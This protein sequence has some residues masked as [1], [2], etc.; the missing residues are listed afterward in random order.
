[1]TL[2]LSAHFYVIIY[3]LLQRV[4]C[5]SGK[6]IGDPQPSRQYPN[7]RNLQPKLGLDTIKAMRMRP[8]LENVDFWKTF[9]K[10]VFCGDFI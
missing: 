9:G 5:G 2:E 7:R 8:Y 10:T 1:M 4:T 6:I 3:C